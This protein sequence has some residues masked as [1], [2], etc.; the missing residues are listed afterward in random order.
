MPAT[1]RAVLPRLPR[2]VRSLRMRLFLGTAISVLPLVVLAIA[3]YLYFLGA[4][5][6]TRQIVDEV[7][8]KLMPVNEL[9][10]LVQRAELGV[11]EAVQHPARRDPKA[12][13]ELEQRIEH[14]LTILRGA[15]DSPAEHAQLLH[16]QSEWAHARSLGERIQTRGLDTDLHARQEQFSR[17]LRSIHEALQD[18]YDSVY[19]AVF[20]QVVAAVDLKHRLVLTM[21][22]LFGTALVLAA[23]AIAL[24]A[25]AVLGPLEALRDG[26]LQ[27]GRGDLAYRIEIRRH[28]ELGEVAEAFNTM[29]ATLEEQRAQLREL[30]T[31]DGL[32]GLYN[33]RELVQRLERELARA[34]RYGRECCVVLL[35]LDEFKSVNDR[36]GHLVGDRALRAVADVLSHTLRGVDT[37]ARYGGEEFALILPEASKSEGRTTAERLR[38][39]VSEEIDLRESGAAIPLSAS[40]GVACFPEAAAEAE[41]LFRAADEA[42][43]AAKANGRNR[44][45]CYGDGR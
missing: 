42:L 44:V 19:N 24:L 45:E 29:A 43:Y 27:L 20:K 26:A 11:Y 1:A 35:D 12:F 23:L 18:I 13:L 36:F 28:D 5:D 40:F 2:A 37:V 3:G 34:R 41:A 22:V 16:I 30:A 14:N 10:R 4:L 21:G 17:R 6:G 32:T 7:Y 39:A 33:H 31:R 15:L 38:R 25:R 8:D 9:Q